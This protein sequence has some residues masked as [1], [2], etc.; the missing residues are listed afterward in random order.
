MNSSSSSSSSSSHSSPPLPN[1]AAVVNPTVALQDFCVAKR[2]LMKI[3]EEYD[4]KRKPLA[5]QLK[6]IKT[7]IK[8]YMKQYKMECLPVGEIVSD[9]DTNK[10]KG[11]GEM[12]FRFK[13]QS[14]IGELKLD[15]IK[16]AIASISAQDLKEHHERLEEK[17]NQSTSSKK[18]KAKTGASLEPFTLLDIWQSVLYHK[19]RQFHSKTHETVKLEKS[20]PRGVD[21]STLQAPPA[22]QQL[23][24]D[25]HALNSRIKTL[26]TRKEEQS[27]VHQ[28]TIEAKE[29][30]VH[31]VIEQNHPMTKAKEIVMDYKGTATPFVIKC[32]EKEEKV[33][34]RIKAFQPYVQ[35]TLERVIPNEVPVDYHQAC[36]EGIKQQITTL[37]VKYFEGYQK[38]K[39]KPIQYVSL[40]KVRQKVG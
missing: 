17:R 33:E 7:R 36:T 2:K 28:A 34:V 37:L 25:W 40:D 39:K 15:K 14:T 4:T 29:T 8:D 18:K 6:D 11:N 23:A 35:K 10:K 9:P 22:V 30:T 24:K 27:Q 32:K 12:Y 26:A 31:Q 20:A 16:Q 38:D 13:K 5:D 19:F 21:V 3:E 1:A